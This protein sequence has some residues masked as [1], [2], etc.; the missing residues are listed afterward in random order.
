M[1]PPFVRQRQ[2]RHAPGLETI[3]RAAGIVLVIAALAGAAVV[4]LPN[5][6][7]SSSPTA[8]PGA[9]IVIA[10]SNHSGE[11]VPTGSQEPLPYDPRFSGIVVCLDPGHGGADRGNQRA[12]SATAPAMDESYFNLAIAKALRDR[13]EQRGFTV[14]MTRSDDIEVNVD[15]VDANLDGQTGIAGASTAEPA[16]GQDFDELQSRIDRCN[17]ARADVLLSIHIG[18]AAD[19]LARGSR[20]W[21][22]SGR[23]FAIENMQLATIVNEELAAHLHAAGYTGGSRGIVDEATLDRADDHAASV[24]LV[25]GAGREELK[26]PSAMPGVV[27]EV[28]TITSDADA[29]FLSTETGL[30]AAVAGLDQAVVRFVQESGAA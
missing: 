20:V 19:A 16:A 6:G 26:E 14:V 2:R 22:S 7:R 5:P 3:L 10:A 27:A 11:V 18:G 30:E 12:G 13:L 25:V 21:Y 23:P 17:D 15:D 28:L 29:L 4:A 9:A 8:T 24:F 1:V